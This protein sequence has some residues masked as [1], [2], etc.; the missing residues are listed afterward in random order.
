MIKETKLK[1]RYSYGIPP[2]QN[3]IPFPDMAFAADESTKKKS[4]I[5]PK[6]NSW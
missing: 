2:L 4:V 3:M 1:A 5:Q 6:A